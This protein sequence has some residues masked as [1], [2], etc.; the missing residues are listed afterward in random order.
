LWWFA[1]FSMFF[2]VFDILIFVVLTFSPDFVWL[3]LCSTNTG[4][5]AKIRIC[6]TQS[7]P[8]FSSTNVMFDNQSQTK[9]L[10]NLILLGNYVCLM[11]CSIIVNFPS[12][13]T[14][15]EHPNFWLVSNK[16]PLIWI[17]KISQVEHPTCLLFYFVKLME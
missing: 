12:N 8:W 4:L 5:P 2:L 13:I 6:W 11:L 16:R 3:L 17:V 14:W 10:S 7:T 15:V 1:W 9:I